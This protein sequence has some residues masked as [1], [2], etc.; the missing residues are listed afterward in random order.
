[1]LDCRH[2]D[3][4]NCFKNNLHDNSNVNLKINPIVIFNGIDPVGNIIF[5]KN[6]IYRG[7][8]KQFVQEYSSI[9]QTCHQHRLLGNYIINTKIANDFS[10][11]PFGLIF[12]HELISPY[13]YPFEWTLSMT[14]DAAYAVLTLVKKLDEVGLGLKDGHPYNIA[15]NKGNYCF[16]D[17]GSIIQGK[18][19]LW[20]FQEFITT[21]IN[22]IILGTKDIG[23]NPLVIKEDIS[24][25]LTPEE[26]EQYT[27]KKTTTLTNASL[28]EI[29]K[30]A[31]SLYDWIK[32]YETKLE[33]MPYN[34]KLP[35]PILYS[36]VKFIKKTQIKQ[37]ILVSGHFM[38]VGFTLN[39]N[40][41]LVTIFNEDPDYIDFIYSQL[42]QK[43]TRISPVLIDFLNPNNLN[44][45]S[46]WLNAEIRFPAEMV[47]V[48]DHF[49]EKADYTELIGKLRL[50]TTKYAA[51]EICYPPNKDLIKTIKRY[52]NTIAITRRSYAGK[53]LLYLEVK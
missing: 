1:M 22:R 4:F 43:T 24:A 27:L 8:H 23:Q 40:D 52:F 41:T 35:E 28:G 32:S 3:E 44:D 26:Q 34:S 2:N 47:I 10:L 15:Y 6:K 33:F 45:G 11:E 30:A 51:I 19:Y 9:Y 25:Y 49:L 36:V 21:F 42:K 50:F 20:M 38:N 46:K 37:V 17:F 39:Q 53:K 13:V 16:I 5:S 29:T 48:F 12:E 7:I 14:I 18:T 31:D